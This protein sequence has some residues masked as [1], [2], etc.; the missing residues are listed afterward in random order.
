MRK[1]TNPKAVA[2][3][4]RPSLRF[5]PLAPI[6]LL[7]VG[8]QEGALKYGPFNWRESG[9]RVSVYV[10]AAR[11]HLDAY[12]AGERLDPYSGVPHLAKAMACLCILL[13]AESVGAL[14]DDRPPSEPDPMAEARVALSEV[15]RRYGEGG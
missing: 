8:M 5:V 2:A 1:D 3:S 7:G 12:V 13:D 10:D 6:Y 15:L 11:R 14:V 4:D 9:A